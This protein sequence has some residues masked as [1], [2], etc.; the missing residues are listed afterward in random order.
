MGGLCN[1]VGVMW[2][3]DFLSLQCSCRGK[4][5]LGVFGTVVS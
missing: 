2:I 1:G 4:L 5:F 3:V